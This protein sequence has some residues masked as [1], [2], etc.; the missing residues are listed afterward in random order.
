MG[1]H[2]AETGRQYDIND[3]DDQTYHDNCAVAQG[4]NQQSRF[5]R[6]SRLCRKGGL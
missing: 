2:L 5:G 4:Y 3:I 6:I 1:K